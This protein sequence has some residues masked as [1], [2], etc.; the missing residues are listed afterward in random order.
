MPLSSCLVFGYIT[1]RG[2]AQYG[3]RPTVKFDNGRK[4]WLHIKLGDFNDNG[5]PN[6]FI[7]I[8]KK[9][10]HIQCQTLPLVKLNVRLSETSNE[11]V[12]RSD[13]IIQELIVDIRESSPQLFRVCESV[14]LVDMIASF[15]HLATIRDYV[16]PEF[17]GTLAIRAGRHPIL[18]KV[19]GQ[20]RNEMVSP[21]HRF[22]DDV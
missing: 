12:M 7:N 16:R 19:Q 11:V 13:A 9:K 5:L 21:A 15:A 17:T 2:I 4:Y 6:I 3:I 14:A 18:D 20:N 8:V 1:Q 10:D 22:A